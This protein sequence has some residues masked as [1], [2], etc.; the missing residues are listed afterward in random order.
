LH[1]VAYNGAPKK[2]LLEKVNIKNKK[3]LKK[4]RSIIDFDGVTPS[5]IAQ[6]HSATK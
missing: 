6:F 4:W 3:S 1:H 2:L 5:K